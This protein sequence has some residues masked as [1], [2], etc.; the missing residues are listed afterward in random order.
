MCPNGAQ[1]LVTCPN[2]NQNVPKV[3][4][5]FQKSDQND[6][7][8]LVTCPKCYQRLDIFPECDQKSVQNTSKVWTLFQNVPKKLPK[9]RSLCGNISTWGQS[10]T[11]PNFTTLRTLTLWHSMSATTPSRCL[12][13]SR[14]FQ[15]WHNSECPGDLV[16]R[17][18]VQGG[19]QHKFLLNTGFSGTN[20]FH[21]DTHPAERG[22]PDMQQASGPT[23][24]QQ[25]GYRGLQNDLQQ[26]EC[27]KV[28]E[29]QHDV[30]VVCNSWLS[31]CLVLFSL[32]L[33]VLKYFQ[34][35]T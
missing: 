32:S 20:N 6:D 27:C 22:L 31:F 7:Q 4:T 17:G 18:G 15:S 16:P 14:L 25:K 33:P 11:Y 8:S 35:V 34:I 19:P 29:R 26:P 3:W 1:N 12:P 2:S 21:C 23:L 9:V 30:S 28:L 5:Y 24:T 10:Q 13:Q